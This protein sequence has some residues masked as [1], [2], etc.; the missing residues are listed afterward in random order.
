MSMDLEEQYDKIYRYCW[1]KVHHRQEAEDITQ[2]TFLRFLENH[3]YEEMGKRLAWLYTTA[4]NLCADHYRKRKETGLWEE[5]AVDGR[6]D[7][8]IR[9]L[10]LYQAVQA[11]EEEEQELIFLR[12]VN[13]LSAGEAAEIL[14]ISRFAVYR[15][16]NKC[17]RKLKEALGEEELW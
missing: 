17:L 4:R 13:E 9:N 8:L 5:T 14:Q 11:L 3:T 10:R 7:E 1:M 2:E 15:R 16:L 6:E 12:Y